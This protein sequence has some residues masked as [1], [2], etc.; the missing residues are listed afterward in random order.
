M[1]RSFLKLTA[2]ILLGGAIVSQAQAEEWY[3]PYK[4][5]YAVRAPQGHLD[6]QRSGKDQRRYAK[7]TQRGQSA[8][9]S[10]CTYRGGPKSEWTC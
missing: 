2:A 7:R 3:F 10:A 6:T 1:T 5:P 4:T 8:P 9:W